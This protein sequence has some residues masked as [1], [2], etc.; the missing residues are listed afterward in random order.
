MV[1]NE[2]SLG[3]IFL[4]ECNFFQQSTCP[5]DHKTM[6]FV[7][8]RNI[9]TDAFKKSL[10]VAVVDIWCVRVKNTLIHVDVPHKIKRL[11]MMFM[12][13]LSDYCAY[14]HTRKLS[15]L[16][17]VCVYANFIYECLNI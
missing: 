16:C 15:P 2:M 13:I 12:F 17:D 10:T 8:I 5:T 7:S 6:M 4:T 9:I 3:I 11:M 1:A 14:I